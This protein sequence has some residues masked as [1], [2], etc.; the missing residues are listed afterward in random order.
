[1]VTIPGCEPSTSVLPLWKG[2]PMRGTQIFHSNREF[3]QK[4]RLKHDSL[5]EGAMPCKWSQISEGKSNE[6]F[7]TCYIKVL[8]RVLES[9]RC[10]LRVLYKN[11]KNCP[12]LRQLTTSQSKRDSGILGWG[13]SP[14]SRGQNLKS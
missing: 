4:K 5:C 10:E 8:S 1:M 6:L 9:L 7:R 13:H 2:L 14:G 3:T 11:V 12:R